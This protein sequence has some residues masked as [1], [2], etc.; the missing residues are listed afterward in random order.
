MSLVAFPEGRISYLQLPATDPERAAEFYAA[1]FGWS[2]RRHAD[3]SVRFDD[4]HGVVS[5]M[6]V[7]GVAPAAVGPTSPTTRCSR[8]TCR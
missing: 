8:S 2:I 5:G 3:G 7:T 4:P 1:V 6:W